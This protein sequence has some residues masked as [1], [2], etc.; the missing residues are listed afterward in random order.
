MAGLTAVVVV[1]ADAH[2]GPDRWTPI[3]DLDDDGE[4]L[5]ESCGWLVPVGDGGKPDHV[6]LAQSYTPDEHVDHVLHIPISMVRSIASI[7][8]RQVQS[9]CATP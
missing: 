8:Q 4:Y 5:V 9:D 1:W 7:T 6:T 3:E 2:A